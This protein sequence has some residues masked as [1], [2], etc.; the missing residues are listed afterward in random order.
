MTES[1][2]AEGISYRDGPRPAARDGPY[3]G[4]EGQIRLFEAA[5]CPGE[6]PVDRDDAERTAG[7]TLPGNAIRAYRLVRS[8]VG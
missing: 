8:R 7:V 2:D 1:P 4:E 5:T 6:H 3:R